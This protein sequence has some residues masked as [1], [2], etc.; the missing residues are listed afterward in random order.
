MIRTP[1]S[2][3]NAAVASTSRADMAQEREIG[4]IRSVFAAALETALGL[5]PRP[6]TKIYQPKKNVYSVVRA[7]AGKDRSLVEGGEFFQNRNTAMWWLFG[8]RSTNPLPEAGAMGYFPFEWCCD[9]LGYDANRVRQ[10]VRA[11]IEK[12]E[13]FIAKL[14]PREL[15]IWR[16]SDRLMRQ[17][18][19]QRERE[20]AA[21]DDL[22][23]RQ[24]RTE[25][26]QKRDGE[27]YERLK[28]QQ[29]EAMRLRRAREEAKPRT[30]EQLAGRRGRR[31]VA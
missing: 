24:R 26:K 4:L 14:G 25:A 10:K 3:L 19:K 29:R 7:A 23:E 27:R 13:D 2:D 31:R 5:G 30:L 8:D 15:E 12:G 22:A 17:Y 21:E 6:K 11:A 20:K 28:Q 16:E 9:L 18:A 1:N